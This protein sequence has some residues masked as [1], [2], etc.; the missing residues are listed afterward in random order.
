MP[1]IDKLIGI[2]GNPIMTDK[3]DGIVIREIGG[4][5]PVQGEGTVDGKEFYFRSRGSSWSMSI[6]GSNVVAK[7]EWHYSEEYGAWPDAGYI[8]EDEARSFVLKAVGLYRAEGLDL[9]MIGSCNCL[10]KSPEVEYHDESC[11]YRIATMR[12]KI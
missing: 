6:G 11:R 1:L 7:P 3:M 2:Y 9:N 10:T 4:M 5:C 8:S 12:E